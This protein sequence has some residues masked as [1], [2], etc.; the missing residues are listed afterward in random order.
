MDTGPGLLTRV[1]NGEK[2]VKLSF[3]A[4]LALPRQA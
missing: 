4:A 1:L 3:R 2:A